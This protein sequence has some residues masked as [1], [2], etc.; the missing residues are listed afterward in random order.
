M[1]KNQI[2]VDYSAIATSSLAGSATVPINI[3]GFLGPCSILRIVNSS[4]N[5][6]LLLM[7]PNGSTP[8]AFDK[9]LANTTIQ[10]SFQANSGPNAYV[11]LMSRG[12]VIYA[13]SSTSSD[14]YISV[15]NY[16]QEN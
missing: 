9:I 3:G 10:I 2:K 12:T 16:Y 4:A 7:G 13:S 1:S 5:D 15:S 6:I 11:A 8:G 14:G